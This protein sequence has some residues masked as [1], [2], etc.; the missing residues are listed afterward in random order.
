MSL[1]NSSPSLLAYWALVESNVDDRLKLELME[2]FIKMLELLS[3]NC[4]ILASGLTLDCNCTRRV[5]ISNQKK[6]LTILNAT[7]QAS[8]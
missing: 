5:D 7:Y 8:S 3:I 1:F 4:K 2:T 6:D